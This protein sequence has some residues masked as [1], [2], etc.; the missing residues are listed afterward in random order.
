MLFPV[1]QVDPDS[2]APPTKSEVDQ[3]NQL[4]QTF[5]DEALLFAR[6][7]CPRVMQVVDLNVVTTL[8]RIV[9]QLLKLSRSICAAASD[10]AIA[11]LFVFALMW[12]LG[13]FFVHSHTLLSL[14]LS[15]S[16]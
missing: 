8:L 16:N 6:K 9:L 11:R 4:F 15:L 2:P 13:G 12:S 3:L 14:S 10:E 7:N 5:M 1:S